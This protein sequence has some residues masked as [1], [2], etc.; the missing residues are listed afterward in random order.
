MF[1]SFNPTCL[2][3][4]FIILYPN[5]SLAQ[6]DFNSDTSVIA[7]R[8]EFG[9]HSSGGDEDDFLTKKPDSSKNKDSKLNNSYQQQYFPSVNVG[10]DSV[11]GGLISLKVHYDIN[12]MDGPKIQGP[13][14][15]VAN[16]ID[17]EFIDVGYYW[18]EY[19]E[20]YDINKNIGATLSL[21]VLNLNTVNS[22]NEEN[23]LELGLYVGPKVGISN[24]CF[25]LDV[26]L[27]FPTNA[28]HHKPTASLGFAFKPSW[29]CLFI[30]ALYTA[31]SM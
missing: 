26:A 5:F 7:Q 27:L 22:I 13:A 20:K 15:K 21:T 11:A 14:V 18:G 10:F 28:D 1:K 23:G 2:F 31:D 16:G 9:D 29:V 3:C 24:E 6:F 12:S 4:L 30:G 8:Y 19:H 25:A 17:A